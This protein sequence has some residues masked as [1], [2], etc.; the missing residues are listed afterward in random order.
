M[1]KEKSFLK[2]SLK[3]IN[4]FKFVTLTL[5]EEGSVHMCRCSVYGPFSFSKFLPPRLLDPQACDP[6]IDLSVPY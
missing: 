2:M 1:L 5:K 3:C 4:K 6:E